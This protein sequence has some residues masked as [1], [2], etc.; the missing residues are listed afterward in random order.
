MLDISPVY[1]HSF[2]NNEIKRGMLYFSCYLYDETFQSD[3]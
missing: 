3:I 1:L 2:C